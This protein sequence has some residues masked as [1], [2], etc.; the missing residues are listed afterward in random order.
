MRPAPSSVP[1]PRRPA[2]GCSCRRT[3]TASLL[4]CQLMLSCYICDGH[5][6]APIVPIACWSNGKV[7]RPCTHLLRLLCPARTR[8]KPSSIVLSNCAI[9]YPHGSSTFYLTHCL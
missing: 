2:P 1:A 9:R 4:S 6:N 3:V 5:M 8:T 7:E